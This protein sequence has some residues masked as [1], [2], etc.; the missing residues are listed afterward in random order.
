MPAN[1][2]IFTFGKGV[3]PGL[4]MTSFSPPEDGFIWSTGLWCQ[5]SFDSTHEAPEPP[6]NG[7]GP[8]ELALDLDV[9]K[10]SP[11]LL[12]QN[13]LFY[14]NGLRLASRYISGRITVM[15]E[16]P[17]CAIRSRGNIIT[18]DTPDATRPADLGG[19]DTRRLGIQL[20]SLRVV[21]RAKGVAGRGPRTGSHN[22]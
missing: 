6:P 20:F 10:L 17:P 11:D 7:V 19:S 16:A 14:A 8:L 4:E 21:G 22:E 15:L 18:I 12:G 9:Y 3:V 1:D 5:L 2:I 13:V